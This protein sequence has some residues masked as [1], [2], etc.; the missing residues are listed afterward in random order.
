MTIK[1]QALPMPAPWKRYR[2]KVKHDKGTI[3]ILTAAASE[4]GA[5]QIILAA[6]QCPESAIISIKEYTP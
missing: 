3:T 1:Q 6:E 4:R 5:R 2:V